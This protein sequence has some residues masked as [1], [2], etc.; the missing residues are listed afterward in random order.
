MNR[1]TI[2]HQL[3]TEIPEIRQGDGF[4]TLFG[5]LAAVSII[6]LGSMG[7]YGGLVEDPHPV[8][9]AIVPL[10]VLTL[11]YIIG[12]F[13][14][15][16]DTVAGADIAQSGAEQYSNSSAFGYGRERGSEAMMF[17]MALMAIQFLAGAVYGTVK[18]LTDR[19]SLTDNNM[20]IIASVFVDHILANGSTD[21]ETLFAL[22]AIASGS[23]EEKRQTLTILTQKGFLTTGNGKTSLCAGKRHLF[24]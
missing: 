3:E 14:H 19:G 12:H 23:V 8:G 6:S 20:A 9:F 13:T 4:A 18:Y 10:V 16:S 15:D 1:E 21:Q 5:L 24:Q 17:G 11:S 7:L 2:Q 22:P